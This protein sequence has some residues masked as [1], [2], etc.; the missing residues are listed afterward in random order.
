MEAF[1][2]A[3]KSREQRSK[4]LI[5]ERRRVRDISSA[6]RQLREKLPQLPTEY[7]LT[8]T[9]TLQRAIEYILYLRKQLQ[10]N[11]EETTGN[12]S[13]NRQ[14]DYE[15]SLALS[16]FSPSASSE[17]ST[18]SQE[19]VVRPSASLS[20]SISF[21]RCIP[22]YRVKWNTIYRQRSRMIAKAFDDLRDVLRKAEF[23]GEEHLSQPRTLRQAIAYIRTLRDVIEEAERGK[24]LSEDSSMVSLLSPCSENLIPEELFSDLFLNTFPLS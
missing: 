7:Q 19:S 16:P 18:S 23:A 13:P 1:S 8:K 9:Q 24:T 11:G 21:G 3:R 2:K 10:E 12:R 6:F 15:N 20:S 5:R 22:S 17:D 14:K 4:M